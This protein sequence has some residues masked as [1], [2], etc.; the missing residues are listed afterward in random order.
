MASFSFWLR[1]SYII[2]IC[3]KHLC[4]LIFWVLVSAP[5]L[6]RIINITFQKRLTKLNLKLMSYLSRVNAVEYNPEHI[7][8]FQKVSAYLLKICSVFG[9]FLNILDFHITY[10]I[11][12]LFCR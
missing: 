5:R 8:D 10:I 11:L 9:I 6:L 4:G 2:R 7:A 12:S 1:I 3:I